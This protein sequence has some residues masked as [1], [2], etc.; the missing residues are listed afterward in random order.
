MTG[1]AT[2]NAQKA[3][4]ADI[5]EQVARNM[6][7]MQAS[8]AQLAAASAA[9]KASNAPFIHDLRLMGVRI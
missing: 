8:A 9:Q 6:K 2:A 7:S 1:K 3:I 5:A 4:E